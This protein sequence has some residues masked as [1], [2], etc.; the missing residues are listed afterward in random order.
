MEKT[1]RRPR[2][3][4]GRNH[5]TIGSDILAVQRAL[6]KLVAEQATPLSQAQILGP[7]QL[8]RLAHVEPN[9]WYPIGWLLELMERID[10]RL[11][12]YALKKVG[13]VLFTLTH[14]PRIAEA[15]SSAR[16]MIYRLDEMYHFANRGEQ[17]G[18]WQVL[19]FDAGRAELE[20]TTPHHC[21]MEEGLL[22]QALAA[23]GAPAV[24]SQSEC[25]REGAAACRFV[26]LPSAAGPKWAGAAK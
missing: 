13:R 9:R 17:I 6:D 4:L 16:D 11:G 10:A 7:E 20:K 23:V 2:G 15:G 22:T 12:H 1:A 5:E 25:F 21:A 24:I 26:I 14:G 18:G 3:Y 8:E 19:S